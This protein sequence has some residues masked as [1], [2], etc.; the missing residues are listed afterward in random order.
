MWPYVS[1]KKPNSARGAS[2][3]FGARF[4]ESKTL[5]SNRENIEIYYINLDVFSIGIEFFA[6]NELGS[7]LHNNAF[8]GDEGRERGG[9]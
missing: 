6:L 4:I 9:A 2:G 5:I 3:E 7:G 1:P 8:V